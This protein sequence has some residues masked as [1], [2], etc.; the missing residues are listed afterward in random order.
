[1]SLAEERDAHHDAEVD[2]GL[3][4]LAGELVRVRVDVAARAA[5]ALERRQLGAEVGGRLRDLLA[6]LRR[7][8]RV[9]RRRRLGRG[10][11]LDVELHALLELVHE[12]RELGERQPQLDERVGFRLRRGVGARRAGVPPR[13]RAVKAVALGRSIDGPIASARMGHVSAAISAVS[14]PSCPK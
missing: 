4:E 13:H 6:Q 10:R 3:L 11:A 12:R 8:A 14:P 1:M 7:L 9:G 2:L 5:L